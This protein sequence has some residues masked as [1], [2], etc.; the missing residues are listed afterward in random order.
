MKQ[1]EAIP[2]PQLSADEEE[3]LL[4][5]WKLLKELSK[6]EYPVIRAGSQKALNEI[7]QVVFELGLKVEEDD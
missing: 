6:S 2:L 4:A 1:N 7:W 3:R 5:A